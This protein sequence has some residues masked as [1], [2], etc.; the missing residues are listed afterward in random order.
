[1]PT[2]PPDAAPE[3]SQVPARACGNCGIALQGDFCHRCG[4][5][6]R[7]LVR[8]FSSILGDFFDTVFDLDSRMARTLGPLLFRPGWLTLRYFEGQRVRYVSPVR[9]FFFCCVLAFLVV[10]FAVDTDGAFA[11]G[12]RDAQT[13]AETPSSAARDTPRKPLRVQLDGVEDWDA[14]TN[15]V[16]VDWLPQAGNDALNRLI[17]RAVHNMDQARDEP[18][19]LAEAF[20]QNLPQALFLLLPLFALLLKLFYLFARRLYM[21]HLIVALHSHAFLCA[22]LLVLMLLGVLENWTGAWLGGAVGT[23]LSW[24]EA[25]LALWMPLYLLLM[26]KRVYGQGWLLT[27]CKY[28][29]L[30]NVYCVLI[31]FV[32]LAALA[33]SLVAL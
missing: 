30:G 11:V 17:G 5:P 15:P 3:A 20:L 7:G 12:P 21:E 25:A 4:Q 28:V 22:A 6:V 8:H 13:A 14:Q 27:L 23:G 26:Q 1:M 19:R 18:G 31:G 16:V 9:L 2:P 24:L 29:V 33:F 10:R 32:T